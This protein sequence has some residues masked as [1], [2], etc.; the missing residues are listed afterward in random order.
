MNEA[1][2][3]RLERHRADHQ[4]VTGQ[5]FKHFFCPILFVDENIQLTRGHVIN[6][7]FVGAPRK[8][9]IQRSDIDSFYGAMFEG[10]YLLSQALPD[11]YAF[12]I[13]FDSVL[14]R[15]CRL[16]LFISG[17]EVYFYP[18]IGKE[19]KK[20]IPTGFFALDIE[21][22]GMTGQLCVRNDGF[23]AIPGW[24]SCE[25]R[26]TKDLRLAT[27]V[28]ALKA[29]HLSMF[30]LFGYRYAYTAA[31][32]LVGEDILGKFFVANRNNRNKRQVQEN[33]LTFFKPYR[34][35]VNPLPKDSTNL[36]GSIKD[37]IFDL[38]AGST[39]LAWGLLVYV[40]AAGR[41]TAVMLPM[42]GDHEAMGIF[43]DFMKNDHESL[44]LM[45][46]KYQREQKAWQIHS[47]PRAVTWLKD[48]DTWPLKLEK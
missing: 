6:K 10:D 28:S 33:A 43:S 46:G 7:E 24:Q 36:S 27:F 42:P 11:M 30:S 2:K 32:R 20:P 38:C 41:V 19:Q 17:K 3:R 47:E 31:A 22:K 9:A 35:M 4:E 29:A 13:L 34:F 18:R 21:H 26:V 25:L 40:K 48:Y 44:H 37:Y 8:W 15:A 1:G 5:P 16:R 23:P 39:R 14:C 45:I 12:D